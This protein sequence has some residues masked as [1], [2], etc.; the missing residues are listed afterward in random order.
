MRDSAD[1]SAGTSVALQ[2]AI[3]DAASPLGW[4]ATNGFALTIQ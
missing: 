1:V 3:V 4:S 2:A